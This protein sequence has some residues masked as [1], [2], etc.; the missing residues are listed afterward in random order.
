[1]GLVAE[2][3]HV[4]SDLNVPGR[5]IASLTWTEAAESIAS[6]SIV[7]LPIGAIEAHGPH[8]ALDTDVIIAQAAARSAAHQFAAIGR[9]VWIAPP[10]SYGVSFVGATFP[11]T[12]PV[13]AD[14]FRGYLDWVLRGLSA[15]GGSDVIVVNA[16]LEPAHVAAILDSCEAISRETG[17]TIHAVDHRQ[18]RWAE[19]LGAEFAGGSRHAGSYETSIVLAA[20]PEAARI[21]RLAELPPVW[22]DLPDRLRSGA[23]TFAE[24]GGT[25]AYFGNPA[26]SS[27][28]EG[29]RLIEILGQIILESYLQAR[30]SR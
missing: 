11:G 21:D 16:H 7:L 6:D 18:S 10:I 13:A 24:A 17:R 12:T 26:V 20:S 19:R 1:M 4:N 23:R 22:I 8:L 15:I 3:V 25:E 27:V 28:E 9:D 29:A 30:G 14:A 5:P 2:G